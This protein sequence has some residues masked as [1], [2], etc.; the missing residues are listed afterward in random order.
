L[1]AQ[2]TGEEI[3]FT[4]TVRTFEPRAA[5]VGA[6]PQ[7]VEYGRSVTYRTHSS[8]A[9][10]VAGPALG[11]GGYA[12]D[13][14]DSKHE[15]WWVASCSSSPYPSLDGDAAGDVVVLGAGI[16]GLTTAYMLAG[17]GR[18][19]TVVEAGTVAA[20]VSGYTT[21]KI[22]VHHNLIYADLAKRH[23]ADAARL[24]ARSQTEA[25]DWLAAVVADTGIDCEFERVPSLVYTETASDVEDVYDEAEAARAAGLAATVCHDSP[26]PW[27][28]TAGVQIPDQAQFHPRR[29]L[30]ALAA[31]IVDLGGRIV[32]RTRAL[33]VT[34][35]EPCIV[36]TDRGDIR[37][38]EVV[39]ATHYPF[40]DRGL[41]FARLAPYRDVVVAGSVAAD[42]DPGVMAIS[43]GSE[44]GGTHSVR[45]APFR[46]GK[47]LLIVTGGQYKTGTDEAVES[48]YAELARWMRERFGAVDV[49]YE[50]S[51]Q[52]TS[53]VDRL[54]Y[55]GLLPNSGD[56]LWVA[57]GF[58]AWGMTNATLAGLLLSDAIQGRQHPFA[59][60]YDPARPIASG[61]AVT[62]VKENLSVGRH[63]V[64]GMFR[65]DISDPQQLKPNEAAIYRAGGRRCAA[66]RDEQGE[67]HLVSAACTHLGCTV[68]WN[69]AERSWDCPCHGSRFTPDGEVLHGPAVEALTPLER[70]SGADAV[71]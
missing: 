34:A 44:D 50:W 23:G 37:A 27:P 41:L 45:G 42:V 5:S 63:L 22:S 8:E 10:A 25:L 69:D 20:G 56:H 66:Y 54:P 60:L 58:S 4:L 62:F 32:E 6:Q 71:G 1:P 48:R 52:D 17:Q 47:R 40:L 53:S 7:V 59:E 64:S 3:H 12:R 31:A 51:T 21:A 36:H 28:I 65:S 30:L 18:G 19:V 16:A 26:L 33:D 39:V 35:D 14:S 29:Y 61:S 15:S 9:D 55:I 38:R 68:A 49:E 43:T 2:P 57:T 67:L 46:D 11:R 70:P 13:M 24:Y